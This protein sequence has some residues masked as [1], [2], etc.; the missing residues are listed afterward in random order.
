MTQDY[1]PPNPSE[2]TLP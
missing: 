2:H 1:L